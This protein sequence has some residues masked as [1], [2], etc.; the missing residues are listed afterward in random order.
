MYTADTPSLNTPVF[1][2]ETAYLNSVIIDDGTETPIDL[3]HGSEEF[4]NP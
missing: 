3:A 1:I 2:A 4:Y